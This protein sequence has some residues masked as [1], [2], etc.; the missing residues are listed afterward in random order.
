MK[1]KN[2]E[3]HYSG[4]EQQLLSFSLSVLLVHKYLDLVSYSHVK[5]IK[6]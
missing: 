1:N 3:D 2:R 4:L 6:K 5:I